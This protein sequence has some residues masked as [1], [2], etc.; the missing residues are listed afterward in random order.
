MMTKMGPTDNREHIP[1]VYG[2]FPEGFGKAMV[3]TLPRHP[4]T[5]HAID[6]EPGCMLPSRRIYNLL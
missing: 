2:E 4:S 1:A 6:M 3:G 5:N